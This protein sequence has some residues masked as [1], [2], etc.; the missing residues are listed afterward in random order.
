[1]FLSSFFQ[2]ALRKLYHESPRLICVLYTAPTCGP[3]RTLKPIL[4]KVCKLTSVV[5][6]NTHFLFSFLL[7]LLMLIFH[8]HCNCIHNGGH[9]IGSTVFMLVNTGLWCF[10]FMNLWFKGIAPFFCNSLGLESSS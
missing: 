2:Y 9:I 3:C 4:T 7:L 1:M 10:I 6:H 8:T 5:P